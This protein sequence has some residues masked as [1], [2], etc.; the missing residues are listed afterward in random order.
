M[1]DVPTDGKAQQEDKIPVNLQPPNN[2]DAPASSRRKERP[3]M[4]GGLLTAR[5]GTRVAEELNTK[6]HTVER[7]TAP[8]APVLTMISEEKAS[9]VGWDLR[10]MRKMRE[11]DPAVEALAE[12]AVNAGEQAGATAKPTRGP[13]PPSFLRPAGVD[14]P[15]ANATAGTKKIKK[16]NREE[17]DTGVAESTG[18]VSTAEPVVDAGGQ[19][20]GKKKKKQRN[21]AETSG[22][23]ASTS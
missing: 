16:R 5:R 10:K 19:R 23:S 2:L 15:A 13:G 21:Q 22:T 3:V 18:K 7:L 14:S 12:S 8:G 1:E 6:T 11:K 4:R 20:Q 9:V 17:G